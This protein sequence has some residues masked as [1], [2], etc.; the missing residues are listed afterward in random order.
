M[1]ALERVQFRRRLRVW[2]DALT[3]ALALTTIVGVG[4]FALGFVTGGGAVRAKE[5]LFV[6]GWLLL[7]YATVRLWPSSPAEVGSSSGSGSGLRSRSRSESE[8][9]AGSDSSPE[10]GAATAPRPRGSAVG[11]RMPSTRFQSFVQSLPPVRW[12][13]PPAPEHRLTPPGKVLVSSLLILLLSFLLET[14]FGVV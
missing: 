12:V 8:S 4:C 1:P 7:A 11:E 14:V 2:A 9:R 3:Y 5:L 6:A 13:Q 10:S